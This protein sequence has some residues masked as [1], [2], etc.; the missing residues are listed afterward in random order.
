MTFSNHSIEKLLRFLI[1]WIVSLLVQKRGRVVAASAID[2]NGRVFDMQHLMIE[3]VFND[4]ARRLRSVERPTD[5]DDAVNVV[6]VPK[7]AAR[8]SRAP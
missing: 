7:H 6:V 5:D 4:V 2:D 1:A 8:F 3:H